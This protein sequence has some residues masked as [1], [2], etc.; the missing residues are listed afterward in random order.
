MVLRRSVY[1]YIN[2]IFVPEIEIYGNKTTFGKVLYTA[3]E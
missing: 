1:E 3:N 2:I